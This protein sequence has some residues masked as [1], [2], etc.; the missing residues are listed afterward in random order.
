MWS[1]LAGG[2][3]RARGKASQKMESAS[4]KKE[5]L[6]LPQSKRSWVA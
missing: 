3:H 5:K 1:P 2:K 4:S 6:A